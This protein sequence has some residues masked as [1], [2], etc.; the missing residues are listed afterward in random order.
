MEAH[1][2]RSR[3]LE[4]HDPRSAAEKKKR[5]ES[6][7]KVT[8]GSRREQIIEAVK[9]PLGFFTLAILI[10]EA[11]FIALVNAR[12]IDSTVQ[13][14]LLFGT[15]GAV[16]FLI[17]L[18]GWFA[19]F[20]PSHLTVMGGQ[21][22]VDRKAE[23]KQAV[24]EV[25]VTKVVCVASPQYF[26]LNVQEDADILAGTFGR[27]VK[28]LPDANK[29]TLV[30]EM[31]SGLSEILHLVSYVDPQDG[32]L[33]FSK[34]TEKGRR[35]AQPADELASDGLVAI[36]KNAGVKLVVLATCDSLLLAVKLARHVNVI[37]VNGYVSQYDAPDWEEVFYQML[38][39]GKPLSFSYEFATS[40]TGVP[41]LLLL[42]EDIKFLLN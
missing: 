36:I 35:I 3:E 39:T 22:I 7:K 12:Q 31:Q 1:D 24:V 33:V 26:K 13:A 19:I 15:G 42:K 38:K 2:P 30:Q 9:T 37:A 8:Q 20:H 41:M 10:V 11:L 34:V 6:Y 25:K 27:L 17:G 5:K 14:V 32:S 21:I 23:P 28:V 18:V 29:Q 4:A 16:L 40:T